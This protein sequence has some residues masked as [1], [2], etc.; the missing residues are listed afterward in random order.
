MSAQPLAYAYA[1]T[2]VTNPD[3]AAIVDTAARFGWTVVS[4]REDWSRAFAEPAS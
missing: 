2:S 3:A 1:G 4:V